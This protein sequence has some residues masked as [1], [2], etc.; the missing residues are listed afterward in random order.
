MLRVAEGAPK[1]LLKSL[2]KKNEDGLT[3]ALTL[4]KHRNE[5][6]KQEV[7]GEEKRKGGVG[8][9]TV[10]RFVGEYNNP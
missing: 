2:V 1:S 6:E 5:G 9:F 10:G 8:G 4:P 7:E 3:V